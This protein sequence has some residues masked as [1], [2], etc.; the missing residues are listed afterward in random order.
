MSLN[1]SQNKGEWSEFYAFVKLLA[2]GKILYVD[3]EAE[4]L[5]LTAEIDCVSKDHTTLTIKGKSVFSSS[6]IVI[7]KRE[8]LD[9]WVKLLY[10]KIS[11]GKK[12]FKIPEAIDYAAQLGVSADSQG[13]HS[14]GDLS[15]KILKPDT[16]KLSKSLDVSVKSWIGSSPTLF[17]ASKLSTRL[18]YKVTGVSDDVLHKLTN[19]DPRENLKVIYDNGGEVHF[20]ECAKA[21]FKRNLEILGATEVLGFA[22]LHHFTKSENEG[23][24]LVEISNKFGDN[25]LFKHKLGAFLRASALG[26]TGGKEWEGTYIASDNVLIVSSDGSIKCLIGRGL[27]ENHLFQVSMIDTPSTNRHEYGNVYKKDGEWRVNLNFQIRLKQY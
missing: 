3:K 6:T 27:L 15:F 4:D 22:V 21:T 7:A 24:N 26:M 14:K 10:E 17:N 13:S 23:S 25:I 18:I 19:N 2:D 11:E 9:N 5:E 20:L 1:I 12:S 16:G 8:L